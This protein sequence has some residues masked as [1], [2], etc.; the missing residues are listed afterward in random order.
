VL[1]VFLSST[2]RDLQA[3]RAELS[4]A[5]RKLD[6]WHSIRMEDFGARDSQAAD[7]C[8]AKVAECDLFVGIVGHLYGSS[9][10]GSEISYTVIEYEEAVRLDRPRLIFR[11]ADDFPVPA[12]L[13]EDE[14]R[15]RLQRE[16]RTRIG[17]ERVCATFADVDDLVQQV[18]TALRNWERDS[19]APAPAVQKPKAGYSVHLLCDRA[20]QED[21]FESSFSRFNDQPGLPQ[22]YTVWGIQREVPEQFVTRLIQTQIQ[23]W[24]NIKFGEQNGTIGDKN[25]EWTEAADVE[26]R[27]NLL[28]R[29]LFKILEY[30]FDSTRP[31]VEVFVEKNIDK[32]ALGTAPIIV[33]RH[34]I[35]ARNWNSEAKAL[36]ERYLAFWDTVA[37]RKP[38][39]QFIVFLTISYPAEIEKRNWLSWFKGSKFDK[40]PLESGLREIS[41]ARDRG[42]S[43]SP[44]ASCHFL[45]LPEL[46][47]VE[48]EHVEKWFKKYGIYA[49]DPDER[50]RTR[51]AIFAG[52]TCLHME[53]VAS[54]LKKIMKTLFEVD[55]RS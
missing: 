14:I 9:P 11:A 20:E 17:N 8:R 23:P 47:C 44:A 24:A 13:I 25:I 30:D 38:P 43:T 10:P 19:V 4:E 50:D 54:R 40:E 2:F 32:N 26:T 35:D 6:G 49:D 55:R 27:L 16:F 31:P 7:F 51:E 18:L 46:H 53:D 5:L 42:R 41:T 45:L 48:P 12:S 39:S 37:G 15:R 28:I 29:R 21:R 22:I 36:L 1:K 52:E 34:D 3:Y 33:I